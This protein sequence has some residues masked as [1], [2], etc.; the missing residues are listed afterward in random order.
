MLRGITLI[1]VLLAIQASPAMARPVGAAGL[2]GIYAPHP[3]AANVR[4]AQKYYD[5]HGAKLTRAELQRGVFA[6]GWRAAADVQPS[7]RAGAG[8]SH[9]GTWELALVVGA[10]VL[11]AGG[12]LALSARRPRPARARAG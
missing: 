9:A 1:G 12:A 6:R 2:G 8:A 3:A 5:K 7:D 10:A 4:A 11:G